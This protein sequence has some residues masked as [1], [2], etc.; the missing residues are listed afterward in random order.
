[1]NVSSVAGVVGE[2][3]DEGERPPMRSVRCAYRFP[4]LRPLLVAGLVWGAAA[5]QGQARSAPAEQVGSTAWKE[6]SAYT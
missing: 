6:P 2:T 5:C 3:A 1:M 4:L